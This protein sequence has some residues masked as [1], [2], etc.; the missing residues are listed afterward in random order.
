MRK[1]PETINEVIEFVKP[2]EEE[3]NL[4]NYEGESECL[5]RAKNYLLLFFIHKVLNTDDNGIEWKPDYNNP[6]ELRY[7][8]YFY[9]GGNEDFTNPDSY[10]LCWTTDIINTGLC[11]QSPE[12]SEYAG[13]TF[14]D[15]YKA[16]YI[17]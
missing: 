15:F 5:L 7:F 10:Y 2:A 12:M 16:A 4:I 11:L 1:L 8:A 14:F 3:L 13:K 6:N 9:K 17:K